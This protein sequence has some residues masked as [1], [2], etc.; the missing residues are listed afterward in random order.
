MELFIQ[1]RRVLGVIGVLKKDR[2]LHFIKEPLQSLAVLAWAVPSTN[3]IINWGFVLTFES[4]KLSMNNIRNVFLV[5]PMGAGKSTIGRFIAD[6][7][8]LT[9]YDTDQAIEERCGADIAWIYDIEGEEGFRIREQK[10]IEEL[11]GLTGIVLA[12]GGG[13]V[14]FPENR[15]FLGGRGF[16]VY[17]HASVDQQFNRTK[18]DRSRPMLQ[19]GDARQML[20]TLT[21]E[22]EP[23]YSEIADLI[24]QT[25]GRTVRSVASEIVK[26]VREF[27][28]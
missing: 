1:F 5:G 13:A 10:I 27:R 14:C 17:L 22:R 3:I 7:L 23:L 20:E 21:E 9:F 4:Q 12:T 25:D 26:G 6:E 18:R 24:V 11:T 16:V 15:L 8:N 28:I 2:V 19:D